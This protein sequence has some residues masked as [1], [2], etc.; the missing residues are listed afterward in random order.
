MCIIHYTLQVSTCINVFVLFMF[1]VLYIVRY[2]FG[3]DPQV[4]FLQALPIRKTRAGLQL[5]CAAPVS[6]HNKVSKTTLV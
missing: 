4:Q 3:K 5:S 2:G 6:L 1:S